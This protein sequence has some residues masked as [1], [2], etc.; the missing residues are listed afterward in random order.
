MIAPPTINIIPPTPVATE[1]PINPPTPS[2]VNT[3]PPITQACWTAKVA[4]VP[5]AEIIVFEF[6]DKIT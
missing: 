5:H 4:T 2:P 3:I 6:K 1:N